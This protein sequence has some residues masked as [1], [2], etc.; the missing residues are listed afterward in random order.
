MA[1]A[2]INVNDGL[3]RTLGN[4]AFYL[5]LLERFRDDQRDTIP[6]IRHSLGE[7]E[8]RLVAERLAHTLKGVAGQLGIT[9]IQEMAEQVV[10]KIR[11]GEDHRMLAPLLD[12]LELD[13]RTLHKELARIIPT[14]VMPEPENLSPEQMDHEATRAI[15]K[16]IAYLLRQYDGDAIDLLSTSNALLAASLGSA[17]HQ[18]IARAARQFDF[19]AALA[20]LTAGAEEAGFDL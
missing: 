1:A 14:Q 10:A 16:R 4:R 12:R 11:R 7:E 19:D 8:D 9:A 18:R 6:R 5:Q 20:A 13:M 3:S 17:A 2:G 15:I